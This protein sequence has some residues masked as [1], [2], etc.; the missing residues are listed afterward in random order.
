VLGV[1]VGKEISDL[2]A[3]LVDKETGSIIVIVATDAPFLPHQLK[4]IARRVPMGISRVGGFA[5][6]GS[7][8]LFVA[9]S[10]AKAGQSDREVLSLEMLTND[11]M[12]DFFEATVQATEESILNALSMAQSMTGINNNRVFRLPHDRLLEAMEKYGP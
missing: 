6:N 7:G 5:A 1:P 9:F 3:A 10:T 12:D 2:Q 4:R 11:L 8:D